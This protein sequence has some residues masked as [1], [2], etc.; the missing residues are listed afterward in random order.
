MNKILL[1]ILVS[2]LFFAFPLSV[3][4]AAGRH[5]AQRMLNVVDQTVDIVSKEM[6]TPD[7][8]TN[9]LCH[10][11][12]PTHDGG[13]GVRQRVQFC[14]YPAGMIGSDVCSDE[15]VGSANWATMIAS[16]TTHTAAGNDWIFISSITPGGSGFTNLYASAMQYPIPAMWRVRVVHTSTEATYTVDCYWW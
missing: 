10:L 13:A 4:T 9:L 7:G 6:K 15:P 1:S 2:V 11:D 3:S 12:I 16:N 14:L 8:V 5:Y